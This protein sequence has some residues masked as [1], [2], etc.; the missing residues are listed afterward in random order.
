LHPAQSEGFSSPPR[1][2][3]QH[4]S[5]SQNVSTPR[6]KQNDGED[7]EY[8]VRPLS[9][10]LKY[11]P[12][13]I[14]VVY[15]LYLVQQ[16]VSHAPGTPQTPAQ[17]SSLAAPATPQSLPVS[18]PNSTNITFSPI[19]SPNAASE[20]PPTG[21]QP[22]NRSFVE[23]KVQNEPFLR[24]ITLEW[25]SKDTDLSRACQRLY[26]EHEHILAHIQEKQLARLVTRLQSKLFL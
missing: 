7:E 14:G 8:I 4:D 22:S 21:Q 12:P 1:K 24:N 20:N 19:T 6:A 10:A 26:S 16:V 25:L 5:S 2:Q 15:D 3:F 13:T 23:K 18:S 9:F 11:N 17:P